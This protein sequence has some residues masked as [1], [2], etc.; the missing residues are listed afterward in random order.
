MPI[1]QQEAGRVANTSQ[2]QADWI[3]DA[4]NVGQHQPPPAPPAP[5]APQGTAEMPS[6]V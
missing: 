4:E 6:Q 5:P 1:T 3:R 2:T